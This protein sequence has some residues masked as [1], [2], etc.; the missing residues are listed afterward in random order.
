MRFWGYIRHQDELGLDK[1]IRYPQTKVKYE[2]Q[3]LAWFLSSK[4]LFKNR[5][6]ENKNTEHVSE[7]IIWVASHF[8]TNIRRLFSSHLT[9]QFFNLLDLFLFFSA[10]Q[11]L[12]QMVILISC[13]CVL[14]DRKLL[15]SNRT[16]PPPMLHLCPNIYKISLVIA[17]K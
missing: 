11:A 8:L 7:K 17:G 3:R 5:F 15:S 14:Q 6:F 12:N 9:K 2:I 16:I 10:L 1:L 4:T 13:F